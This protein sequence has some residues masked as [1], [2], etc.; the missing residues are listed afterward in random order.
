MLK[1]L[2]SYLEFYSINYCVYYL[3]LLH[4][5]IITYSQLHSASIMATTQFVL[6]SVSTRCLF[7][8]DLDNTRANLQNH[9]HGVYMLALI[10]VIRQV[11]N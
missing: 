2:C 4:G 7:P 5:M 9:V 10:C 6:L 11:V 3:Y 1:Q 8:F